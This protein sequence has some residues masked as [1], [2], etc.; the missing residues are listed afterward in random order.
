LLECLAD[1]V[2]CGK[3]LLLLLSD[4]LL[5]LPLLLLSELCQLLL[6]A[7]WRHV[8]SLLLLLQLRLLLFLLVDQRL[9]LPL[10]LVLEVVQLLHPLRLLRLLFRR[11]LTRLKSLRWSLLRLRLLCCFCLLL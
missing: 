10:L 9:H 2:L 3:R 6:L 7:C 1:L 11:E 8:C 4:Q 5:L